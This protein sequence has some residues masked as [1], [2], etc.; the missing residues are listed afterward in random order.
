MR[1]NTFAYTVIIYFILATLVSCQNNDYPNNNKTELNADK[2]KK[3]LAKIKKNELPDFL[4]SSYDL[5]HENKILN[6]NQTEAWLMLFNADAQNGDERIYAKLL[7]TSNNTPIIGFVKTHTKLEYDDLGKASG[8]SYFMGIVFLEKRGQRW[9]DVSTQVLPKETRIFLR[10]QY[11]FELNRYN[12]MNAKSAFFE[13]D[14]LVINTI[15]FQQNNDVQ[16][17][18]VLKW[19]QG[20]YLIE[21]K[22]VNPNQI[23]NEEIAGYQLVSG[24]RNY[25]LN[26]DKS[27]DK[28]LFYKPKQ[29][30][31]EHDFFRV[32]FKF[33]DG[34][35]AIFDNPEGWDAIYNSQLESM[36][37]EKNIY[38]N[39]LNRWNDTTYAI[40]TNINKNSFVVILKGKTQTECGGW[41][42]AFYLNEANVNQFIHKKVPL[43]TI[44][45][46]NND[47]SLEIVVDACCKE[48]N[49][50]MNKFYQPLQVYSFE[51][52]RP[53]LN[54]PLSKQY[55]IIVNG[56]YAGAQCTEDIVKMYDMANDRYIDSDFGK[57]NGYKTIAFQAIIAFQLPKNNQNLRFKQEFD[58]WQYR[59]RQLEKIIGNTTIYLTTVYTNFD[60][61]KIGPKN[62]MPI[63]AVDISELTEMHDK[64]YILIDSNKQPQFIGYESFESIFKQAEQ[65]F[66]I[67][68][69]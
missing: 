10:V 26:N 37:S 47:N 36:F 29:N 34:T 43:R 2:L 24:I 60:Q 48:S 20:K 51:E 31:N 33:S 38:E 68:L 27:S 66:G 22:Q 41:L 42:S 69:K 28:I 54:E 46:M 44:Q 5:F 12:F 35:Q 3:Y 9:V 49:T 4:Q 14:N 25:D 19:Q 6:K 65:Y 63:S 55:N 61:V 21:S 39:N 40:V 17:V 57:Q 52:N 45:D 16:P 1:K 32:V 59:L 30:L 15:N 13:N 67:N 53:Y 64:G 18:M 50:Q 23:F 56:R 11:A 58:E 7:Q 8:K 62:T